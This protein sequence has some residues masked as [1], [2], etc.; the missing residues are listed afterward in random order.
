MSVDRGESERQVNE[1]ERLRV[2]V[3]F[4]PMGPAPHVRSPRHSRR[5]R[6]VARAAVAL[7]AVLVVGAGCGTGESTSDRSDDPR[8]G[9]ASPFDTTSST[10][11]P[12]GAGAPATDGLDDTTTSTVVVP[13][14]PGAALLAAIDAY[15]IELG[16]PSVRTLRMTVHFPTEGPAYSS[17]QSQDPAVPANVDERDWRQGVVG[18]STPVV[19]REPDELATNL[20]SLDEIDWPSVAGALA[21]AP[22][23][24]E[25]ET[26]PLDG[27]RGVTHLIVERGLPFTPGVVVRA[28]VDGGSRGTGG[29]VE[30]GPDGTVGRVQT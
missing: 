21:G 23:L 14:D 4:P 17:L 7:V 28:Y 2:D 27:A 8:S 11:P 15:R 30:Y 22:A 18:A 6:A 1:S 5:G 26:G 9:G 29:Y 25:A 13:A 12:T 20:F 3:R 10:P 16:T 24:V 19:V